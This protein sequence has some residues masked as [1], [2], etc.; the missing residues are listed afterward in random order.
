MQSTLKDVR[1]NRAGEHLKAYALFSLYG[2]EITLQL[3]GTLHTQD[4]AI[5]L[6][7]TAGKIGTLLITTR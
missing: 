3:E 7:P 2:K 6:T 1:M 5:R 4:G